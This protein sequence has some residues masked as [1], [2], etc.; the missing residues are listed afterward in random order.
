MSEFDLQSAEVQLKNSMSA[1]GCPVGLLVTPQRLWLYRD[2]YLETPED[3]IVRE[4]EFDISNV[5]MF[6]PSGAGR[7]NE[8]EFERVVQEWLESLGT[9]AGL[10]DLPA[11]LKRAAK[12]YIV[13]ALSQGVV[14][15]AHPRSSLNT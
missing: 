6:Q 11:E 3:S 9:E 4:P 5:L 7:R 15:A 2:R 14:R 1:M 10:R 8:L 12:L 13:P